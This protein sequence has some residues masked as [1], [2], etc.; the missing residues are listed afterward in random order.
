MPVT[1]SR[2]LTNSQAARL[3][4]AYCGKYEYQSTVPDPNNPDL[5]IPNPETRAQFAERMLIYRAFKEFVIKYERGVKQ[6]A[7]TSA[8]VDDPFDVV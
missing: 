7:A 8:I 6:E 4:D 3:V 5:T 1:I 2:T